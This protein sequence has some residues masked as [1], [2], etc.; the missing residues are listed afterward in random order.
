MG[1]L[2]NRLYIYPPCSQANLFAKSIFLD[3]KYDNCGVP[4]DWQDEYEFC[5]PDPSN[6]GNFPNGTCPDLEKPAP[7][8]YDWSTSKTA[9]RYRA[10][11]DAI[12]QQNRTILYSLCDWGNAGVASWGNETG[13]SWRMSGDIRRTLNHTPTECGMPPPSYCQS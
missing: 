1:R 13:A 2:G 4:D 3:L 7:E 5:V 9:Q 11:R 12:Q 10:M 6:G 8:G